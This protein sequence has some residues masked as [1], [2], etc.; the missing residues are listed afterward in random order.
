MSEHADPGHASSRRRRPLTIIGATFLLAALIGI[1]L[2]LWRESGEPAAAA[3][4]P[5]AAI[6]DQGPIS[7]ALAGDS[8]LFAPLDTATPG[9]AAAIEIVRGAT[10]G[11]TNLEV[12]L[13]DGETAR[14]ADAHPAPRWVHGS[15]ANA[16]QLREMGFDLISLANN[17]AV[18]F[19]PE[20]LRSTVKALGDAGFK[21]A[22]AGMDLREAR[23]PAVVGTGPRRVAL[24]AVTASFAPGGRASASQPDIQGRPGVSGLSYQ[25]DITVDAQTFQ[26]LAQSIAQLNAGPPAGEHE[27]TMFG[28]RIRKG[29]HT[30][31]DFHVDA[32]DQQ[33]VLGQIR[34]A[35]SGAE[36]VVVS[37]HSHEPSNASDE[38]ADFIREFAHAAID[39]GAQVV[40]GHGPHRL[41]GAEVYKGGLIFYS[42]GNFLYQTDG[43]DFRAADFFDAGKDL[44][45]VALGASADPG[46]ATAQLERDWWWESV[47]A[48]PVFENGRLTGA[49]IYPLDLTGAAPGA[50]RGVPR[51]ASGDR[52]DAILRHFST[53]SEPYA[54]PLHRAVGGD[55]LVVPIPE[56]R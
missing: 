27:L 32:K 36:V 7:I 46:A 30:H 33:D 10:L 29:D 9:Y 54:T 26:T 47:L 35:R 48:V 4:A 38:P 14:G 24:V 39:A 37:I 56:F 23:A 21:S 31:I 53:L 18:D 6:P 2:S 8:S 13:L 19:G 16:Q 1:G 43:L 49:R 22:G 11:F 52:A 3:P 55:E 45:S 41:R 34:T 5:P 12:D 25:A 17:H 51:L 20:G 40:V 28:T 50:A 42:L 15:P 44:Y